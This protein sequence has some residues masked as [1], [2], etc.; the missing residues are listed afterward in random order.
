M[1]RRP[2]FV[3]VPSPSARRPWFPRPALDADHGA[4]EVE[5]AP[6]ERQDFAAPHPARERQ[7]S[8]RYR[9]GHLVAGGRLTPSVAISGLRQ[10]LDLAF[11]DAG[12]P[13]G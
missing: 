12:R 11:L 13:C 6:F 7:Y 2:R 5:V 8:D 9:S 10:Y 4:V 1:L 3:L